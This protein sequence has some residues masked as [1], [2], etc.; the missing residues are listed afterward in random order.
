MPERDIM[1]PFGPTR[2]DYAGNYD[3]PDY[4]DP[5]TQNRT[6]REAEPP[7]IYFGLTPDYIGVVETTFLGEPLPGTNISN[8][9]QEGEQ[10]G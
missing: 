6:N 2:K 9:L 3:K 7:I 8:P 5:D 1:E 10:N 4:I